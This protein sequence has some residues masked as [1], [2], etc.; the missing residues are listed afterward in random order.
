MRI[1]IICRDR[2][3]ITQEILGA[4]ARLGIDLASVEVVPCH[5]Y[6]HAPGLRPDDLERLTPALLAVGDV[7]GVSPVDLL[8]GER[9]RMH[10]DTLLA[11]L[12]DPVLTVDGT[13]HILAAN[14]AALHLFEAARPGRDTLTVT[15]ALGADAW[16]SVVSG[17]RIP[18]EVVAAGRPFLLDI[19]PI[20]GSVG[21]AGADHVLLLSAPGV[22][23]RHLSALREAQPSGFEEILGRSPAIMAATQRARRFAEVEAPVLV[24]GETG[25]GKELFARAIHRA[26][27]RAAAPFLALNCAALPE[28]LVESELFG[29]APGAFSGADRSG[30]PGLMELADGGTVF[31]DEIGEMSPYVQAKLLRF[32]EDGSFRRVGGK[33]ERRASVRV[34]SATH[35]DLQVLAGEGRFREDLMY[36]LAVLTLDVPPL[37]ARREDIGLL[38][39]V[40][41]ARAAAQAGRTVPRLSPAA[42]RALEALDWPGNVR[43]LQNV[44]FRAVTLADG[45]EIG[46]HDLEL[47]SAAM[48]GSTG[49]ALSAETWHEAVGAFERSLLLSLLPAYPSTRRLAGRLGVSHTMIADKL[50]AHGLAREPTRP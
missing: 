39:E 19:R 48:G 6:V 25:S 2:L 42:L 49:A 20:S 41:V 11:A 43:Q 27:P 13:G 47:A 45:P 26:G 12:P 37:R 8:P 3:G 4:V 23:G 32:L 7:T 15:D 50:R 22:V 33:H 10:L 28:S 40:F 14:P 46:P 34:I 36:R 24:L 31:L 44:L 29:Y 21:P 5:V 17:G 35:R 16:R 1:D 9:R 38:V 18:H 30:K